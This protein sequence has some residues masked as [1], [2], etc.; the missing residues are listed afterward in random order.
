MKPRQPSEL[1]AIFFRNRTPPAPLFPERSGRITGNSYPTCSSY[2]PNTR[3]ES[4]HIFNQHRDQSPR[5]CQ[6]RLRPF[7]LQINYLLEICPCRLI[8]RFLHTGDMKQLQEN[9][10]TQRRREKRLRTARKL[11]NNW[12]VQTTPSAGTTYRPHVAVTA[13]LSTN[14][15]NMAGVDISSQEGSVLINSVSHPGLQ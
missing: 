15:A 8:P 4:L 12:D 14:C 10:C 9:S 3:S 13:L 7:S 6:P 5:P 11:L 1:H 2:Q